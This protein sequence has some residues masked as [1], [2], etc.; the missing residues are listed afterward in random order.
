MKRARVG[1]VYYAEVPNGYKIIQWAY[2]IPRRGD[3]IRVFDGLY[4]SIPGNIEE[5]V[6]SPHS[7][8]ISFYASRAYRIGLFHLL[9]NYDVPEEYPF[10]KYQIRF[11]MDSQ[12]QHVEGIHVMNSD[13]SRNTWEWHYVGRIE[14]LPKEY[15]GTTLLNSCVTP[16]WLLFL[17]DNGFDLQHPEKFSV[18]SNPEVTLRRY[19]DMVENKL[20]KRNRGQ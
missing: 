7:Y 15:R 2:S 13:G 6:H 18:G 14:D 20:A 11:R 1:D 5:I 19:T 17:F 4:S 16:N 9:G 10:P 12:N 8:I 3:Y